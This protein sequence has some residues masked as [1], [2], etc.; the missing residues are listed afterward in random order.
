[1]KTIS[2]IF[3]AGYIILIHLSSFSQPVNWGN[4]PQKGLVFQITNKEAQKLLTRAK[5]DTVFDGL[6]YNLVDSFEVEKGWINHC[7]KG[8]FVLVKVEGNKL[9]CSYTGVFP[10]QVFLFREYGALSL[11][12]T[13]F[14]GNVRTDAKVKL[15]YK[16]LRPDPESKTYRLENEWINAKNQFA[17]VELDGFRSVFQIVKHDVPEWHSAYSHYQSPSFYSYL[18]TDKNKYRPND[19][20]RFKSYALSGNKFPLRRELEVWVSGYKKNIKLN[21]IKPHRP[22]SYAGELQLHDSLNL[23]LDKTYNLQLREKNGKM[24]SNCSFMYEDY[25]LTGNKL[26][27]QITNTKHYFPAKNEITITATDINGLLLKDA[28]AFILVRTRNISKT[29]QPLIILPDTLSYFQIDLDPAKPTTVEILPGLFQMSNTGYEVQVVVL[30]TQYQRMEQTV[31]ADFF[32]SQYELINKLSNDSICFDIIKNGEPL[33]NVPGCI[34]YNNNPD[35]FAIVFPY[36][37]KIN[38]LVS[39]IKLSCYYKSGIFN[40]AHISPKIELSGGI[41]KD[42]FNISLI[43]PHQLDVSWYVYQGAELLKKG[44]GKEFEFRSLIENRLK[45]YYVELIYTFGGQDQIKRF[46]FVFREEFLDVTL[47][48]PDKV[49]PGQTIDAEIRVTNQLGNPVSGVDLTAL[50]VTGKLNYHLPDL[51]YYGS[52]SIPR[53][54]S[55]HF[56]KN[57]INSRSAVIKLNYQKWHN[58]FQLDTMIYYQFTYPGREPF[59]YLFDSNDSTQFAPYIMQNGMAVPI[60]VI[61]VDRNPVYFSWANRPKEYSFYISPNQKHS[62]SLRLNDRV[63]VLDSLMFEAGKKTVISFDMNSL[64]KYSQEIK[65]SNQLTPVERN[66]YK[67]LMSSVNYSNGSYAWLESEKEFLPLYNVY[68]NKYTSYGTLS[69]GPSLQGKKTY[70]LNGSYQIVYTHTGGFSYAFEDNIV[71]KLTASN[72]LP[73]YLDGKPFNP[74]LNVNDRVMNKKRFLERQASGGIIWQPQ[75]IDIVAPESR[76]KIILP[77][78]VTGKG[79]FNLYFQN[80]ESK[81]I[82]SPCFDNQYQSKLEFFALPRGFYRIIVL[83]N[84]GTYLQ[85]DSVDISRHSTLVADFGYLPICRPDTF[86]SRLVLNLPGRNYNCYSNATDNKPSPRYEYIQASSPGNIRGIIFDENNDPLPGAC[87]VIKG[88]QKGTITDI[89]GRFSLQI[90]DFTATLVVSFIGYLMEEIEVSAGSEVML[91]MTPDISALEEVVVIGYG[92]Q[93]KSM[94]TGAVSRVSGES[95]IAPDI[96]DEETK[97]TDI[98]DTD[99]ENRLYQELLNLKSIRSSFSDV[100]FWEPRLYTDRKGESKFTVTFPDDITR[101]DALVYAMNRNLH[102]GTARKTIKSYKPLMAEL[103]VPNFLARGD[104]AFFLGKLL[105]YTTDSTISGT[106]N[107]SGTGNAFVR[108]VAFGQYRTDK[109]P[110]YAATADSIT[111]RYV[112]TRNDGYTDGEERTVRVIEQGTE[113]AE[114]SL[115]VLQN[116]DSLH[117]EAPENTTLTVEI[118]SSQLDIYAGEAYNL[119]HYRYDCNEQLASKLVGLINYK[120]LMQYEGKAFKYDKNVNDIVKRL[121]KNQNRE[122]LWSWW[123]VTGNTSHWMSAH[124]LRALK[125]A[126]DAGYD[127]PLN[128]ENIARK[129]TYQFDFLKSFSIYDIDLLHSLATWG[130]A[131][132]YGEYLQVMD[133]LLL[134]KEFFSD[135]YGQKY[136]YRYSLLTEKLMLQ[137]IRQITA[138]GYERD[139]LLKYRKEGI[140]GEIFFSDNK[141]SAYWHNN[142]L[143]ANA[144]AYRLIKNDTLL[145]GLRAS[146]QLYFLGQRKNGTWNTYQSANIIQCILPDIIAGRS[147]KRQV[148]TVALAGKE[149]KTVSEFPF[150]MVLKEKEKLSVYKS[151]GVPLYFVQYTNER[152]TQAKTGVEGFKIHTSFLSGSNKLKAGEPVVLNIEVE[153]IKD[154]GAEHVMIEVPIPGA[155]SY[156]DKRQ[157]Q[158]SVET[159]REYFSDRTVLFCENMKTGKYIFQVNLLPRFTGKYHL[160]PAQVSLMYV[161]VVNA[162]TNMKVVEVWD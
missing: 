52:S 35:S 128:I 47:N 107:W 162:N 64:K 95:S 140:L 119:L 45:T 106:V 80:C 131:I 50:A 135:A 83:Y 121:L 129:A 38:P 54:K 51:P 1:M 19:M 117:I 63:V 11:Q 149:N 9:H 2:R 23:V 111:T 20:L 71:Y 40:L 113:R 109:L 126:K 75:T 82:L 151:S 43:N 59:V 22:G 127:V 144:A 87:I 145:H 37:E 100:G 30:N 39:S 132:D 98:T 104:S 86:S 90:D 160:N 108:N 15:K 147:S 33:T 24:V 48:V 89:D 17:T 29:F 72:L 5:P 60:Y 76:I 8:H 21:K 26:N 136:E 93:H 56:T 94:L 31:S 134:E 150:R 161:P 44:F 91:S 10:Y 62:I 157:A 85:M 102:T 68:N 130:A 92:V 114:G 120:L 73:G 139:S 158:N 99:A 152:V 28:K 27:V 57:D 138:N 96:M 4:A 69:I 116:G 74:M 122:F 13:D 112:F 115:S 12:V 105:N 6:L 61:E 148:A 46:P 77:Q 36:K 133:S 42:S 18:I 32:Y 25:E 110:V 34:A 97:T 70:S 125:C 7:P 81:A 155:C 3:A 67:P 41:Q 78:E 101:W 159:H 141:P 84:N 123:N 124:I 66:R 146:M 118:L 154:A 79:V 14:S 58:L 103:H 153:V 49:Y 142:T 16:R 137:E 55:A 53:P 143:L 88:T 65:L 156:A